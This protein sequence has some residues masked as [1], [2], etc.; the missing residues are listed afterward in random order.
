M[1]LENWSIAD[2]KKAIGA[3]KA[4]RET[5]KFDVMSSRMSMNIKKSKIF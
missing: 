5:M 1:D 4:R 2:L 3:F